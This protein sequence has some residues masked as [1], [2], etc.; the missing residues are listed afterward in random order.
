M[1]IFDFLKDILYRKKG[2]LCDKAEDE[3][4]F[5]AYITQRWLSMH[6][7]QVAKIVNDTTN[8]MWPIFEEKKQWYQA[9]MCFIPRTVFKK[10]SYIKKEKTED[11][12]DKDEQAI[13][14]LLAN[15]HQLS[16]REIRLY[17]DEYGL[18]IER[19]KK[20]IK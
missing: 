10:I 5:N 11:N 9:M 13:I 12:L 8:R 15:N 4:D 14:K 1:I 19:F 20:Q 3:N 2:N 7:P 6:S 16:Q 18:D 17:I